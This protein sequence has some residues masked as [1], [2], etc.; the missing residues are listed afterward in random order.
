MY[1]DAF[2]FA[3]DLKR[4]AILADI[5]DAVTLFTY[6]FARAHGSKGRKPEP[7]PRPWAS[8]YAQKIGSDPIPISEF[9][10]WYYG[11]D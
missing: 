3:S 6:T 9:D 2:E 8:G 7:Y 11:G 4:N 1:P 10:R 5:F